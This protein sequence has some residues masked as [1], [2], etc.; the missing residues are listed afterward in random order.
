[1]ISI[2]VNA[3]T[4]GRLKWGWYSQ[5]SVT[6]DSPI[7]VGGCGRSGTTLLYS[8]LNSHSQL[9]LGLETA[10]FLA[11]NLDFAHLSRRTGMPLEKVQ[12]LY[13][14]SHCS[15]VFTKHIL[16]DLMVSAGK[17]RWG[18]KSPVNV[19]NISGI[20]HRFPNAKFVHCIRDG[21]D[22]A[23]SLHKHHPGLWKGATRGNKTDIPWEQC[24]ERW[25]S[26]VQMGIGWRH[27]SRYYDLKYEDLIQNPQQTLSALLDWLDLPWDPQILDTALQDRVYS[28]A[29]IG[30][31]INTAAMSRWKK[32][33]PVDVRRLFKGPAQD[34]LVLLGYVDGPEWIES[35]EALSS[36]RVHPFRGTPLS[37]VG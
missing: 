3:L 27:D 10:L 1:M 25:C 8:I 22:V 34:L 2:L 6:S 32:D 13:R 16:T 36:D 20:F 31:P 29:G 30:Q 15:A 11:Y 19:T 35:M 37:E 24:I 18:E 4:L 7:V 33:L 21:R 28:H 12:R 26:Q 17:S 9:F 23:C 14:E 5:S